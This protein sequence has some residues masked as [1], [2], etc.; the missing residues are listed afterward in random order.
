MVLDKRRKR[1]AWLELIWPDGGYNAWQVEATIAKLLL[2]RMEIVKR[3]RR[4]EGLRRPAASLGVERTF[5]S[6]GRNRRLARNFEN[7]AE[8]LVSFVTL[9]SI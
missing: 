3:Q 9:A 4:H 1:F 7:L 2:L 8:T 6:F 5:S